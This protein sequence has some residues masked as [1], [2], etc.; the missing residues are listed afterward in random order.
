M[1]KYNFGTSYG[2]AISKIEGTSNM[3]DPRFESIAGC[4]ANKSKTFGVISGGQTYFQVKNPISGFYISNTV[5]SINGIRNGTSSIGKF[6]KEGDYFKLLISAKKFNSNPNMADMLV[7]EI[8]IMLAEF[9][10]GKLI[11]NKDWTWIDLTSIP[12]GYDYIMFD[13][14]SNVKNK[15]G[16]MSAS[17]EL[18]IDNINLKIKGGTDNISSNTLNKETKE[19]SRYSIDGR[20][21][22]SPQKGINIIKMSNGTI[23]KVLVK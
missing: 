9:K 19:I 22:N 7:G 14:D 10:D 21:L 23:K 18:C 6:Q 20:R 17:K 15:Y 13:F 3:N 4:G 11:Y 8:E 12:K 5:N 1:P 2:I 16:L